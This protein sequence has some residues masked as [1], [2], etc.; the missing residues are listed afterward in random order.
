MSEESEEKERMLRGELYDASDPELVAE[1][2]RARELVRQ[3]NGT[4]EA[5][6]DRR[7]E[8]LRELFG[9]V[10][11]DVV[12]EPPFRCD[13][14]Y[15]VHVGEGFYANFD[16]VVL[17]VCRVEFGRNCLLGPG[18]HVYTATHPL[19]A[20]E[21]VKGPEYG[22]PVSVGDDVWLG[23]RAVLNPGVTVGD[24]TVVASGAVVTE[25]VPAG[26]VVGGNPASVVRKLETGE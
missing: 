3:Y 5:E 7:E 10:E 25:D 21:R 22:K 26:V 1:R 24:G 8:L 23:G 19:D 6:N 11:G 20:A 13:Y 2:R 9:T 4:M 12:V 17:D 18:V 14:G 15:N 16:C